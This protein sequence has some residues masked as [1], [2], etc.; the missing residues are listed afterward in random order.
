[1][2]TSMDTILN[3][4][5]SIKTELNYIKEHMPDK[6]NFMSAEET[7]LLNE[8]YDNEANNELTSSDD[9]RKELGL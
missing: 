7:K 5:K 2:D 9:L 4:L 1:M 8:S 6:D 3:E